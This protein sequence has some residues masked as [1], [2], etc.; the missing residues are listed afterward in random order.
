MPGPHQPSWAGHP[1]LPPLSGGGARERINQRKPKTMTNSRTARIAE[2]NDQFRTTGSGGR[3]FLTRGVMCLPNYL[4]LQ[5]I[6]AVRSFDAFTPDNDPHGEHDFGAVT[7]EGE[8]IFWK[9][10]YYQ[11]NMEG[12]LDVDYLHSEDPSDPEHT[13]RALTIMLAEEY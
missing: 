5:I 10:D 2:L 7:I 4:M 11:P 9:I 3:I 12:E 1:P 8:K 13:I 6:A